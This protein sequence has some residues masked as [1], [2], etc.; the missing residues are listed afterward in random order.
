[1]KLLKFLSEETGRPLE[2]L[3]LFAAMSG[4]GSAMVVTLANLAAESAARDWTRLLLLALYIAML[5]MHV[6]GLRRAVRLMNRLSAEAL[7]RVKA[8]VTGKLAKVD[9]RHIERRGQPSDYAPLLQDTSFI[10]Q[11]LVMVVFALDAVAMFVIT[12]LYMAWKTPLTFCLAMVVLGMAVPQLVRNYRRTEADSAQAAERDG[13]FFQLFT[14]MVKGFKEV[15]LNRARGDALQADLRRLA[16]QA[17]APRQRSNLR[18]IDDMQFSSGVF[19]VLLGLLVFLLPQYWPTQSDTIHQS[20]ATILFIMG[21]LTM[22]ANMLPTLAKVDAAVSRLTRLEAEIDAASRR[23]QASEDAHA[24]AG[25]DEALAS[26]KQV[27]LRGLRFD[28]TNP[29]GDV[30]FRSGPHDLEIRRG[31]LLF[32]VGGNGA[33]KSTF[34][35][36]LTGLYEPIDGEIRVDGVVIDAGARTAYRELFAVV[37]ADFHLF[38]EL[39]G[40]DHIDPVEVQR[41]LDD[42]GLARKTRFVGNRFTHT[43]LSTGQRKRLAFMVAVL[44]K[45]PICIFD[46]LAADQDPPFRRRFYEEILPA[47][48]AGGTTVVVV[49]HDDQYFGCADRLIRLQDGRIVP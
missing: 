20:I 5:A 29:A 13:A 14:D 26:F 44:R 23:A 15:K 27:Q 38:E 6:T 41:W 43:D 47:L 25:D 11:G 16:V 17:H 39:D 10:D 12:G 8:R 33:G 34:L 9:L 40:V 48:R 31:E 32:I 22:F 2:P 36:L 46:E 35:K 19:Y 42:L 49:S 45:K 24:H 30:S 1:M 4:V 7:Q 3:L 18:Q 21:P 28:Y 37:F